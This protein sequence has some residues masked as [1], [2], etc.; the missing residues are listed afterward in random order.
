M[1]IGYF[2]SL[3]ISSPVLIFCRKCSYK[4]YNY[5]E[6]VFT[7]ENAICVGQTEGYSN[8]HCDDCNLDI[9]DAL[10]KQSS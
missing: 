1:I 4:K 7:N 6:Y 8:L 9:L 3:D 5:T 10:H 2:A